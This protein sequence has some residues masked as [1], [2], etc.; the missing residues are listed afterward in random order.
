MKKRK[1][2]SFTEEFKKEAVKL[3]LEKGY[4]VTEAARSLGVT[5]S[6]MRNWVCKYDPVISRKDED[7]KAEI[8]K[9]KKENDRLRIEREILKKAA[10]F[11]AKETE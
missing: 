10:A 2:R 3:V 7:L 1:R 11:F 9:L 4:G 8:K 5:E 6:S